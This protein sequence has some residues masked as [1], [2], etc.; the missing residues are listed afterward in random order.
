MH[1]DNRGADFVEQLGGVAFEE[2]RALVGRELV[3]GIGRGELAADADF[4]A[5]YLETASG[6]ASSGGVTGTA[7]VILE[8]IA[9][10]PLTIKSLVT[11]YF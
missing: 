5:V 3:G 8:S 4:L 1:D 6:T 2:F 10:E 9:T 11:E 7:A